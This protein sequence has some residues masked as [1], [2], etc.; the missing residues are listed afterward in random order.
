MPRTSVR[1]LQE[2]IGAALTQEN[3]HSFLVTL[4]HSLVSSHHHHTNQHP[5]KMTNWTTPRRSSHVQTAAEE[6][7]ASASSFFSLQFF[8]SAHFQYTTHTQ[9]PAEG[10]KDGAHKTRQTDTVLDGHGAADGC[11]GA[12]AAAPAPAAEEGRWRKKEQAGTRERGPCD[13][14][15]RSIIRRS[16]DKSFTDARSHW[17]LLL[18]LLPRGA[19]A[20]P[21]PTDLDRRIL[22]ECPGALPLPGHVSA[23]QSSLPASEGGTASSTTPPPG[24]AN[25][26]AFRA[27]TSPASLAARSEPHVPS[28]RFASYRVGGGAILAG[29]GWRAALAVYVSSDVLTPHGR[30]KHSPSVTCPEARFG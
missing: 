5:R 19:A 2:A 8:L 1:A 12:A 26:G 15:N 20:V 29:E 16:V 4:S 25:S 18:M 10:R 27:K 3:E 30:R 14:T 23:L 9:N 24:S 22:H 11:G 13:G 17:N 21:R 6:S 7:S 28:L